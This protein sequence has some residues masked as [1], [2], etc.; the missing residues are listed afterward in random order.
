MNAKNDDV[1]ERGMMESLRTVCYK[2]NPLTIKLKEE[3]FKA[4]IGNSDFLRDQYGG[5]GLQRASVRYCITPLIYHLFS[6]KLH[7]KT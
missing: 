7:Q 6:I 3:I 1:K 5:L 2:N 4:D